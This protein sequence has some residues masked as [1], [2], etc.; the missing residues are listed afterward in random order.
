MTLEKIDI[1]PWYRLI[2][3]PLYRKSGED[4]FRD[5][6]TILFNP[7]RAVALKPYFLP[8]SKNAKVGPRSIFKKYR[9]K[10][11]ELGLPYTPGND[12]PQ[13]NILELELI[14][15]FEE[16]PSQ[17]EIGLVAAGERVKRVKEDNRLAD[18]E[19]RMNHFLSLAN[20]L[21]GAKMIRNYASPKK[22]SLYDEPSD[23][24]S[25]GGTNPYPLVVV[26][27]EEARISLK[28]RGGMVKIPGERYPIPEFSQPTE[29]ASAIRDSVIEN[30]NLLWNLGAN[31]RNSKWDYFFYDEN[32]KLPIEIRREMFMRR[33]T[34]GGD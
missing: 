15:A 32:L 24:Y 34:W 26:V 27:K 19:E 21:G 8:G 31:Q 25:M 7:K 29:T 33:G 5:Y 28:E 3:K 11:K 2:S 10:L 30:R 14:L 1:Q 13:S 18:L 22:Y 6:S 9:S 12:E 16:N 4:W 20:C 17:T 23:R